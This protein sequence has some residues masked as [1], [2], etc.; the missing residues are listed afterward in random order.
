MT[1]PPRLLRGL[2]WLEEQLKLR[3]TTAGC[4]FIAAVAL[5]FVLVLFVMDAYA[6]LDPAAGRFYQ[7]ALLRYVVVQE[8]VSLL[9]YLGI[10]AWCLPRFRS[11]QPRPGLAL[12]LITYLLVASANLGILYGH[13]DT[14][15]TLVFLASFV[16]A[17]SWFPLRLLLPGLVI[18]ALMVTAAEVAISRGALRYAPLLAEPVMTGQPLAWWWD[19][20]MRVLFDMVVV[21][22]AAAMFFIFGHM[23]R[24]NR[25]LEEL[26]RFDTLTGLLNR[27]SFMSLLEEEFSKQLRTRRV[28]CVMMCDVD[29]FKRINDSFGHPVG[30]AV[31]S[32]LGSILG[33]A[34]RQPVDVPARFGGEEFVILLPE[35]GLEAARHVAERIRAR[36]AE[37][38]FESEG[39]RF[40]ITLSIGLAEASD[41]DG[42]KAL[43]AADACLYR[44]KGEGRD[45]VV[46]TLAADAG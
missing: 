17:R 32:R 19:I 39:R 25:E 35:T 4:L 5:P 34:V 16:L 46:S 22:F 26:T 21:F 11:S 45:R 6:L 9:L 37:A 3:Y 1:W 31:L 20:W 14:P 23:E 13:K 29:D 24:R 8:A 43:R 33:D 28:A 15:M 27:G 41:G 40:R 12:A 2:D 18:S 42:E 10:F 30:D 38:E 44:A 7:P 36:L